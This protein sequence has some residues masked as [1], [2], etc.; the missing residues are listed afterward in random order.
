MLVP[1]KYFLTSRISELLSSIEASRA[2]IN[3][4]TIPPEV[5][6]NIRRQSTLKSSLFSARIEGNPLTLQEVTMTPSK[7]QKKQ[8]VYNIFKGLQLV[9]S[10][11]SRDLTQSF[12]LELH[13]NVMKGL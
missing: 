6:A 10:R 8:E 11:G 3:S 5:E 4:I 12:V 9:H 2:V 7:D 13:K 1:P